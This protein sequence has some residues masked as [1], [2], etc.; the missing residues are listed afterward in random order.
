MIFEALQ[1]SMGRGELILID[2]ALCR[3]RHRRDGQITIQEILVAPERRRQGIGSK[4]LGLLRNRPGARILL[5]RCPADLPANR[6]W[7][8]RGFALVSTQVTRTGR[9]VN[10]WAMGGLSTSTATEETSAPPR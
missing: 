2:G 8:A 7:E 4:I 6:W 1:E 3:F 9:Q 5:A 10:V